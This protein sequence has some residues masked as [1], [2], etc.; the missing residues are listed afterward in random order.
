MFAMQELSKHYGAK[1][2]NIHFTADF[3]VPAYKKCISDIVYID[4]LVQE[5]CNSSALA[6]ELTLSCTNLWICLHAI[7]HLPCTSLWIPFRRL[8]INSM[9]SW[10]T[11]QGC[12]LSS[13]IFT[14]IRH[15]TVYLCS[16]TGYWI[17]VGGFQFSFVF[18]IYIVSVTHAAWYYIGP[19]YHMFQ[20]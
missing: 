20:S 17:F 13:K 15:F 6:M 7:D 3:T 14:I 12:Q 5:R 1:L 9:D 10:I 8:I 4:V 2:G 18:Y 19:C 16:R 11:L